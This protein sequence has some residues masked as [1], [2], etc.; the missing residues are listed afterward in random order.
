MTLSEACNEFAFI[1]KQMTAYKHANGLLRL[2]AVTVA[3]SG[4]TTSRGITQGILTEANYKIQN[5]PH[6]EDVIRTLCEHREG[7]PEIEKRQLEMFLREREA[8]A[9]IPKE[10]YIAYQVMLN[11]SAAAWREAK[12]TNDFSL[13]APYL[14]KIVDFER[15]F[16]KLN[17]PST[18]S[19]DV[20]LNKYE[21]GLTMEKAD[22]FFQSVRDRLV[23]LI[24]KIAQAE[25]PDDC[26][27]H[28]PFPVWKQRIF[29]DYLLEVLS[30]DRRHCSIG[31]TE[32]PFTMSFSKNDA[33]ITTH[34]YEDNFTSSMYSVIHEAG[35]ALYMMHGDDQY[36]WT[37][38]RGGIS[39]G[40]HESQ[41]RFYENLI[42]RSEEFLTLILPKLQELFPEQMKNVSARQL[43]K[44][45]NRSE[46]SLIRIH[47]DEL[48]YP[49]H[50]MVRYDL[51]KALMD[52]SLKVQDLPAAWN[53]K[54]KEYLGIDV[55]D[56]SHGVLQDS[57]WGSGKIGYFPS[58]ALGSAYGVQMLE[59]MKESINVSTAISTQ[60]IQQITAWLTDR[61]FRHARMYD[62]ETV[63]AMACEAEFD[64]EYYISYLEAK[65]TD[66]YDL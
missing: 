62:P 58:Y 7:L 4:S 41:S 63:F 33:R 22:R 37:N 47:A 36:E 29:S 55:P 27:L 16:S 14:E 48:T 13:F 46:P 8:I 44:A 25:Q 17:Y 6:T 59:K 20:L 54:M 43:Y 50:I 64:P 65:Y 19:Y 11:Q 38:L 66:I 49:L 2:D 18:P 24:T 21:Y 15:H 12:E 35:H 60:N 28:Q 56:D 51:E 42:G 52:G 23:P 45:I 5:S 34:Y 57:H 31:E 10:E 26:F 39:M 9:N 32:H 1:Q 3:P 40:I 30:V 61:I 53:A